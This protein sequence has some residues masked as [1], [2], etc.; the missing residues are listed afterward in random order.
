MVTIF[1]FLKNT[2]G[3]AVERIALMA[4]AIGLASVGGAQ[5]MQMAV[6]DGTLPRIAIIRG[7]GDLARLAQTAPKPAQGQMGQPAAGVDYGTTA[8]IRTIGKEIRLDPCTGQPK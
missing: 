5:M 2:N 8:T 1:R 4:G 7:D 3:G 6:R